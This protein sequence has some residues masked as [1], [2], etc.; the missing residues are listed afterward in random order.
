M[1]HYNPYITWQD[2]I[3]YI[4]QPINVFFVAQVIN[5]T[6]ENQR[7]STLKTRPFQKERRI[8]KSSNH[9]FSVGQVLLFGGVEWQSFL[10]IRNFLISN[11][12]LT[13]LIGIFWNLER[14][15]FKRIVPDAEGKHRTSVSAY[16]SSP[17]LVEEAWLE[18]VYLW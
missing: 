4:T 3:P 5:Y 12:Q 14:I 2:F 15:V 9:Y 10:K 7:M 6:P 17:F 13:G 1:V 16:N 8:R 18:D 11:S